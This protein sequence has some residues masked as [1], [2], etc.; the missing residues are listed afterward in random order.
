[1]PKETRRTPECFRLSVVIILSLVLIQ[2]TIR[3]HYALAFFLSTQFVNYGHDRSQVKY[4]ECVKT[5]NYVS[6]FIFINKRYEDNVG[7][8][9]QQRSMLPQKLSSIPD[10]IAITEK[11][12]FGGR[13]QH[14]DIVI[15]G[16]ALAGQ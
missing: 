8:K 10:P 13:T 5:P 9:Y 7:R 3:I 12:S 4:K 16:G 1:M 2:E 14:R 11:H 15:V 6:R